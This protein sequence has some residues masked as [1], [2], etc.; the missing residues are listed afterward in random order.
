MRVRYTLTAA[1]QIEAAL[2]YLAAHSPQ[3]ARGLQD[4]ILSVVALLQA[5]PQTGRMTSRSHIRRFP[6]GTHP[7]LLD[8][9]ATDD[10]IVVRRFRHAARRPLP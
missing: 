10:E 3:A 7:Y 8:Y 6:L 9:A 2:D 5:H 1:R 4:R